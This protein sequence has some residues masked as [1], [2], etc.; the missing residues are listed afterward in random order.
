[1]N[2]DQMFADLSEYSIDET[3]TEYGRVKIPMIIMQTW[4][5]KT[6]P[7]HWKSS[8]ESIK[9]LMP[10][11]EHVLM[12][13]DDNRKFIQEYFPQ[14]L[15][16]FDEFEYGIQRA[17]FIRYAWLY[18]NGGLYLDLDYELVEP[19]EFRICIL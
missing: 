10:D 6:V 7:E 11:W 1:M 12:T 16:T 14:Y 4:K 9:N 19:L 8:P 15:T 18:I 3:N 13:D 5:T 17:D 2:I